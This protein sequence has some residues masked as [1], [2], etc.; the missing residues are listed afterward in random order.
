MPPN[1]GHRSYKSG[2]KV[3]SEEPGVAE[4][5]EDGG[6]GEIIGEA[7]EEQVTDIFL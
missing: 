6:Y 4:C 1:A 3:E 5:K 7:V 2:T